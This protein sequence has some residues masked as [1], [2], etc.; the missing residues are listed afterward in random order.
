MPEIFFLEEISND[1]V[2]PYEAVSAAARVA[3][4]VNQSR[5]MADLPEGDE[6]P[7]THA[8]KQLSKGKVALSYKAEEVDES[9][10]EGS[11]ETADGEES[12]SN[13]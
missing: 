7:T 9:K 2:N 10:D 1:E 13:G 4:R 6:K 12:P 8:L 11:A 3:R 5:Q